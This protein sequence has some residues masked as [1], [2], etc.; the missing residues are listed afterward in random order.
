VG[1]VVAAQAALKIQ[2]Q[3]LELLELLIPVVEEAVAVPVAQVLL[4]PQ[5]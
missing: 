1:S 4:A 3:L 5:A 2:E